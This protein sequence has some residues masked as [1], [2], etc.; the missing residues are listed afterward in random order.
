RIGPGGLAPGAPQ[1]PETIAAAIDAAMPAFELI[2]DRKAHYKST[3]AFSII[4]DNCWNAGVVLG[5]PVAITAKQPLAG[6]AGC[7]ESGGRVRHQGATDGP[8]AA[9]AW[10]A[11]LAAE[12]GRALEPG[13]IVI[14][15]S[16]I[17]TLP[18]R[19]GERFCFR[20]DGFGSTELS[21]S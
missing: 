9:L 7:L 3:K 19:A 20:L 8:L 5:P 2:E 13:I 10:V 15:G 6:M 12:R 14:T 4:A 11:N 21:V 1:T 16:V 18:I 17:P